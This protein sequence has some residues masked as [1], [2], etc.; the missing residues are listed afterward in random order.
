[1][2]QGDVTPRRQHAR[3]HEFVRC[4]GGFAPEDGGQLEKTHGLKESDDPGMVAEKTK[5]ALDGSGGVAYIDTGDASGDQYPPKLKP[6]A[7]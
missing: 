7:V 4:V 1:M 3:S 2:L 5:M 6:D